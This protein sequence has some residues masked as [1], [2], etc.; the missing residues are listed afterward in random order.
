MTFLDL[1]LKLSKR[2]GAFKDYLESILSRL[3]SVL[4][5]ET[6]ETKEMIAIYFQYSQ[7]LASNDDMKKANEQFGDILKS[8]GLGA[9]LIL[10]FAPITFPLVVKLGQKMGIDIIP[11]SL[12]NKDTG[13]KESSKDEA[14]ESSKNEIPS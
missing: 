12:K 7:G 4:S 9:L 14:E 11:S 2:S 1:L 8:L 6:I 5:K 10:P 3:K 13:V